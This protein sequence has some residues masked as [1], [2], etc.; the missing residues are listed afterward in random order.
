MDFL[1]DFSHFSGYIR[2]LA[3]FLLF[4]SFIS[5][6]APSESYKKYINLV[7]GFILMFIMIEPITRI[8]NLDFDS[9]FNFEIF[10]E[11]AIDVSSS[12][13][14]AIEEIL[15]SYGYNVSSVIVRA[16]SL[17]IR[18]IEIRLFRDTSQFFRI[19]IIDESRREV[20]E[21][22]EEIRTLISTMYNVSERNIFIFY[23]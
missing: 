17:E 22:F 10:E 13:E 5:I 8:V 18:T 16:D 21:H 19:D 7:A 11:Q 20:P 3:I 6:V 9:V 4:M 2:N 14:L 23:V 12:L 1:F 15:E